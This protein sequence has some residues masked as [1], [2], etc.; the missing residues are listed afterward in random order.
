MN[1]LYLSVHCAPDPISVRRITGLPEGLLDAEV[2]EYALQRQRARAGNE[3]L[4]PHL[5]RIKALGWGLR[6]GGQLSFHELSGVDEA[7]LL[8]QFFAS[9]PAHTRLIIWN[10]EE[11]SPAL[12]NVRALLAGVP[13]GHWLEAVAQVRNLQACLGLEQGLPLAQAANLLSSPLSI[14]SVAASTPQG[15]AALTALMWHRYLRLNGADAAKL[16]QTEQTLRRAFVQSVVLA[17]LS[18]WLED[19]QA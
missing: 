2:I 7:N 16:A 14:A 5:L 12:L 13:G 18:V 8:R 11:A 9:I 6:E 10:A 4:P 1:D 19:G 17:P 3:T 15:R